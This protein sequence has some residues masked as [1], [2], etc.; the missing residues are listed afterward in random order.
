VS[1]FG[2]RGPLL[3][4][5]SR[6]RPGVD[7]DPVLAA[8]VGAVI[9]GGGG[10]AAYGVSQDTEPDPAPAPVQQAADPV[11]ERALRIVARV[12]GTAG[13]G[14]TN[15]S[16]DAAAAAK[17]A[18][19]ASDKGRSVDPFA[20]PTATATGAAGATGATS[21]TATTNAGG[22]GSAATTDQQRRAA[23]AAALAS[24]SGA[25]ATS[26]TATTTTKPTTSTP[27]KAPSAR[28]LAASKPA[29]I[30]LRVATTSGRSTRRQRPMGLLV[31]SPAKAVARVLSVSKDNKTVTLR[32][33]TGATLNGKQSS[34]TRCVKRVSTGCQLVHVRTGRTVVIRARESASGRRG[35]VTALRVLSI[36]RGGYKLAG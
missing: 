32:L 21:T 8:I 27:A 14:D 16:A 12:D 1:R 17:R 3:T 20:A 7:I 6:S 13:T 31:P 18:Q 22:A 36:W 9:V 11:V 33:K 15:A 34:G 4:K 10:L 24:G 23:E 19:E 30:S 28:Q 25:R 5:S 2:N 26:T 29:K 35:A